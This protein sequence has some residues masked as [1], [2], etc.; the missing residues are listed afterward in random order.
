MR[1]AEILY[2]GEAV[3]LVA[4]IQRALRVE[5]AFGEVTPQD[6]GP[7]I[8]FELLDHPFSTLDGLFLSERI[9]ASRED[10]AF[11]VAPVR[12][13]TPFG[14]RIAGE[15]RG[16]CIVVSSVITTPF[17]LPRLLRHEMGHYFG[18]SEHLGCVMSPYTID[19]ARFCPSCVLTLHGC[20]VEWRESGEGVF[21]CL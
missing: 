19:D 12:L 10:L 8:S 14:Y 6:V 17:N 15:S 7:Y 11:V 5:F 16:R 13:V 18:L 9:A 20:G 3:R 2:W 4:P 21:T 1:R